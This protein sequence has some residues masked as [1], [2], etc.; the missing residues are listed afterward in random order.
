LTPS[1]QEFTLTVSPRYLP[2]SI[3][4]PVLEIQS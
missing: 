4:T 2:A 1:S 3:Q